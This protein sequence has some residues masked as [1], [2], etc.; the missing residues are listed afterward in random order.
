MAKWNWM[1][2]LRCLAGAGVAL[3]GTALY[4]GDATVIPDAVANPDRVFQQTGYSLLGEVGCD[5]PAAGACGPKDGACGN[6]SGGCNAGSGCNGDGLLGGLSCGQDQWKLFDG[7]T[8]NG[9]MQLGYVSR[10]TGLFTNAAENGRLNVNQLWFA[11]D[12]T[13][14]SDCGEWGW[15]YHFDAVYGADG[16]NTQSFGNNAGIYDRD[17]GFNHGSVYEWALPQLYVEA[18]NGDTTI[19]A[20]HFYTIVGY[21]VVQATGNQFFSHAYTMNNSEPFTHTGILLS[22]KISEDVTVHGGWTLGWD[23]GFDQR[24]GGNNFLGGVGVQ[25][26]EATNVTLTTTIGDF[27][28][29]GDGGFQTS[30]V[31][32]H[33][34]NDRLDYVFQSDSLR[35][36]AIDTFGVNQYLIYQINDCVNAAT[37]VEWW[38]ADGNSVYA[39]T[40]GVNVKPHANVTIRP[41]FRYDWTPAG[42]SPNF[43]ALGQFPR[44][45]AA[46][47]SIDAIFTF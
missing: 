14:T 36:Q 38:K 13:A 30:L 32:K 35:V 41:E 7:A 26:S 1:Q 16:D 23:T 39:M 15:G 27:G 19:K 20:G 5:A 11:L 28:L 44:Q 8:L 24:N 18:T 10:P 45:S 22:Q 6:N 34:V 17:P 37:R 25:A 43:P 40:Y 47:F 2:G 12:K 21:E 9:W 33:A 42:I 3:F 31:V 46:T 4:A 29:I